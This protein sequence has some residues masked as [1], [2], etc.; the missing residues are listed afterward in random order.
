M[1]IPGL[2]VPLDVNY[3]TDEGIRRAGPAAE[4]LYIRSLT[5]SKRTQSDGFLPDYDMPVISVGLP[6][7]RESIDALVDREL[8]LATDGGWQ[9]RSWRR[10]NEAHQDAA[11]KRKRAADRQRRNRER[12]TAQAAASAADSEAEGDQASTEP[13]EARTTES[14]LSALQIAP[15]PVTRDVRVTSQPCHSPKRREEKTREEKTT[16]SL[17]QRRAA[18]TRATADAEFDEFYA[19]YPKRKEKPAAIKAYRAA[20][21]AGATPQQIITAATVYAGER[22]GQDARYTK[23]P[24]TWLNKGCW[25]DEPEEPSLGSNVVALPTGPGVLQLTGT[26]ARVAE[27]YAVL[28]QMRAE[29]NQ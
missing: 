29:R 20:I 11:D 22:F 24:A 21:K 2:Y 14:S 16:T 28:A 4:L 26:D 1:K 9:I 15:E 19:A 27:H 3:V 18:R 7:V 17:P 8:W 23:L 6:Q 5:Y 12:K 13:R 25:A 10:W